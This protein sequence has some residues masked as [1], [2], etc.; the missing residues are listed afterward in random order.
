MILNVPF[1]VCRTPARYL[2]DP[3]SLPSL[4]NSLSASESQ[5]SRRLTLRSSNHGI[6]NREHHCLYF[7]SD[8]NTIRKAKMYTC[9]ERGNRFC[10]FAL[11]IAVLALISPPMPCLA[12]ARIGPRNHAV[13]KRSRIARREQQAPCR[14]KEETKTHLNLHPATVDVPPLSHPL[15]SAASR[16]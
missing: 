3:S 9:P 7:F 12:V 2:R 10:L 15:I 1:F 13:S 6:A 5:Y 8:V 14:T 4:D 16:S 11:S